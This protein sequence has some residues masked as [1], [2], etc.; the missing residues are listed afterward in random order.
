MQAVFR[1]AETN[2]ICGGN[3]PAQLQ[4]DCDIREA[5]EIDMSEGLAVDM[6]GLSPSIEEV[7]IFNA[8]VIYCDY[9]PNSSNSSFLS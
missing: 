2:G 1:A 6:F 3:A 9:M 7:A 5:T 4:R 8:Q